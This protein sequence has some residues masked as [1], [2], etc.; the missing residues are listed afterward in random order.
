MT[1]HK[2]TKKFK[3][4]ID[5]VDFQVYYI[6]I[7]CGVEAFADKKY[8]LNWSFDLTQDSIINDDCDIELIQSIY[9]S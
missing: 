8:H 2:W 4:G 3:F 5:F 7:R 1:P 9:N 6:C